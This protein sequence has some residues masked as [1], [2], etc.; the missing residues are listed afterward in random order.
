MNYNTFRWITTGS[1]Y[2]MGPSRAN[3]LTGEIFDADIIFDASMV[4][5]Y[6]TQYRLSTGSG[7]A[8]EPASM[9]EAGRKGWGLTPPLPLAME[10]GSWN[11]PRQGEAALPTERKELE[12]RLLAI[13]HGM[14]QCGSHRKYE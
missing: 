10:P 14:C 3:P 2:A 9:I 13:R 11:E 7:T 8:L 4:R 1:A 5:F 12:K 6:K